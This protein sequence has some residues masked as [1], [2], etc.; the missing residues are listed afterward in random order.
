[1]TSFVPYLGLFIGLEAKKASNLLRSHVH[2]SST[3]KVVGVGIDAI[4]KLHTE[5]L[6][7]RAH[8]HQIHRLRCL[9][10]FLRT[11]LIHTA[12]KFY[13]LIH[14]HL[15][16]TLNWLNICLYVIFFPFVLYS[17]FIQFS[18]SFSLMC[19]Y[20]TVYFIIFVIFQCIMG[21]ARSFN[22]WIG[23][24]NSV[25]L[26]NLPSEIFPS[27]KERLPIH[28]CRFE[29]LVDGKWQFH[30]YFLRHIVVHEWD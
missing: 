21:L 4:Q 5:T 26:V 29:E 8:L 13:K 7:F 11:L 22:K 27:R 15:T 10:N 3:N 9:E 30:A 23:I 25:E 1:M 6:Q 12:N 2:Y 17:Y 20:K 28:F 19:L 24:Y 18:L 16:S 14:N